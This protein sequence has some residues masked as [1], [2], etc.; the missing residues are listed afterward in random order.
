MIVVDASVLANVVGDDG[1]E[2]SELEGSSARAAT[3]LCPT[4]L[5]LKPWQSFENDG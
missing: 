5:M 2:G 4:S 3:S 1:P